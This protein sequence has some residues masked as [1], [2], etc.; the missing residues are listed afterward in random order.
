MSVCPH[1]ETPV[2]VAQLGPVYVPEA[3]PVDAVPA[4]HRP[5]A[6]PPRPAFAGFW[7]RAAACLLDTVLIVA[8]FLLIA[9]FFP[10]TFEKLL[11]P[12]SASLTDLPQ[13]API[14]VVLLVSLGC[15]YYTL[16]ESSSWQA[17]PGKRVFR[18]Y[19]TDLNEQ[20]ITLR[21]A[22]VRSLARQLS[23]FFFV[24]YVMAGF[25]EKKQALHDILASCLVLR[26]R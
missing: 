20:R 4:N 18:I 24:G 11:P 15:V 25:T 8:V 19:V 3:A 14:V 7:L 2:S 10:S 22:L 1:C 9:S 12:T 16:F 21:R 5:V 17:T 26:R 6:M 13:P 23:G